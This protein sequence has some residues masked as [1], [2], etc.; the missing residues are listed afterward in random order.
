MTNKKTIFITGTSSG[1][2]RMTAKY[3]AAKGWNVAAT[4]RN[5]HR[6]TDL[7][8]IPN[9][10]VFQL[11]VTHAETIQ[12]A[13]NEAETIFG[14]VDVVVNNAGIGVYGALE[15]TADE[16]I[17]QQYLVNVRGAINVIRM[18]LPHFRQH[19]GGTFINITSLMGLS[20]ALPLGSLYNMSKFAV[21]GLTEGLYFEL[22]PLNINLHLV[23]PGGFASSFG[24][25]TR[26]S[27][28]GRIGDYDVITRNVEKAM[29]AAAQ[30]GATP[31]PNEIV[32]TIYE[33]ATGKKKAFRTVIGRDA[34][35]ILLLRKLLPIKTFLNLLTKRFTK[36]NSF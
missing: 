28:S 30:P 33:L 20:T 1:L 29:I 24:K 9:I 35:M 10:K 25:N 6:E 23:E 32:A 15:L 7:Q 11:D 34:K 19:G 5:L 13:L 14:R 2:G 17:D 31:E 18:F 12:K 4:L 16:D 27:K 22:R 3:F 21:E 36:N 26:F 8:A